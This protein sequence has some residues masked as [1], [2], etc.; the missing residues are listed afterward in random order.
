MFA[1]DIK[2]DSV[3]QVHPGP[4]ALAEFQM[5][6]TWACNWPNQ[7]QVTHIKLDLY[8]YIYVYIYFL[9]NLKNIKLIFE[10]LAS[11]I[12]N[13]VHP[14]K[15]YMKYISIHMKCFFNFSQVDLGPDPLAGLIMGWV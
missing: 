11:H 1:I 5:V 15:C 12:F 14:M 7:I 6:M 8:I 13:N 10:Y 3:C 2:P 4:R 9:I